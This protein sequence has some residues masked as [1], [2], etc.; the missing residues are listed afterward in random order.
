MANTLAQMSLRA[1][2]PFK[3]V[4]KT[5]NKHKNFPFKYSNALF[6]SYIDKSSNV[7]HVTS[8]YIHP[9]VFLKDAFG[10]DYNP[11]KNTINP[12]F[13]NSV[14]LQLSPTKVEETQITYESNGD[15]PIKWGKM[16]LDFTPAQDIESFVLT[17]NEIKWESTL[18]QSLGNLNPNT[19]LYLEHFFNYHVF[20]RVS[21]SIHY[22][23]WE[24]TLWGAKENN[25][26]SLHSYNI[27]KIDETNTLD[28]QC[29]LDEYD[30]KTMKGYLE[31]KHMN[32]NVYMQKNNITLEMMVL[33]NSILKKF[34]I[35]TTLYIDQKHVPNHMHY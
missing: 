18:T 33:V 24:K 34:G 27:R 35:D 12:L 19:I 13:N 28:I 1:F 2:A 29:V 16:M 10:T 7:L 5:G 21:L 9:A 23:V 31:C 22:N 11:T 8:P 3:M 14:Q 32:R 25:L 4:I 30:K 20:N 15:I 17:D 26:P 6:E